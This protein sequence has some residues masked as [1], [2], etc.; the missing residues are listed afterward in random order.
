MVDV[1]NNN[2]SLIYIY[3]SVCEW[4]DS[5]H[6]GRRGRREIMRSTPRLCICHPLTPPPVTVSNLDCIQY[7]DLDCMWQWLNDGTAHLRRTYGEKSHTATNFCG[8]VYKKCK[9]RTQKMISICVAH[10]PFRRM[11][12]Y[13]TSR[14]AGTFR[15]K[16]VHILTISNIWRPVQ[17]DVGLKAK[18][19]YSIPREYGE[20]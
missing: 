20:M 8:A 19:V 11:R 4:S 17:G 6:L 16:M 18:G 3:I 2:N 9:S 1:G 12:S 7:P 10:S 15:I 13:N 14:L 5:S